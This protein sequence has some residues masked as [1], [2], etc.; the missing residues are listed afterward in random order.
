MYNFFVDP[1]KKS[2]DLYYI[3]DKDYNHIKNVLRMHAG[4]TALVSCDGRSDLCV[5]EGFSDTEAIL[6]I[7]E[8]DYKT[9]ELGIKICLFQGLPKSDK[10]ELIIQ[11]CVEL[12]VSEIIPVEMSRCIVKLDAGKKS[13]KQSR[14]QSISESA[15]KQ[16]KRNIIPEISSVMSFKEALEYARK[17]DVFI[18][19][20]ENKDGMAS[21]KAALSK[22][23]NGMSVGILIGPEGGFEEREIK[24][25]VQAGAIP[26][27]L[28][29]RI[30]RT[31]TAAITAVGMC[32]LYAEINDEVEI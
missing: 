20:Y 11:K 7:T 6:R 24:E 22:I 13:G 28:G 8:K 9:T 21:T 26:V 3:T 27:S 23:K 29:K 30:L 12:G 15:A 10:L 25:A 5:I 1:D 14:W 18:V 4:D 19:P 32:M 16:S 17:T 2:D 31:E